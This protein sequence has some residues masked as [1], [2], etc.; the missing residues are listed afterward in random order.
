MNETSLQSYFSDLQQLDF[1]LLNDLY[2]TYIVDQSSTHQVNDNDITSVPNVFSHDDQTPQVLQ[3]LT[4]LG[5]E[6]IAKGEVA[7]ILLAGG[8]GNLFI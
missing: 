5:L 3:E 4:L 1:T 8:Q 6:S 2:Q 7:I